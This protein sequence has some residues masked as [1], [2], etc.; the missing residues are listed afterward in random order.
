M[1][2]SLKEIEQLC[3]KEIENNYEAHKSKAEVLPS[4]ET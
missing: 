3:K 2:P 4:D 1:E